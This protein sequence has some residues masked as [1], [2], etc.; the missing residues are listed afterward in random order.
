MNQWEK[1]GQLF[2]LVSDAAIVWPEY[3]VKCGEIGS[4]H[5]VWQLFHAAFIE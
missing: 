1:I 2:V 3:A 4:D 5:G